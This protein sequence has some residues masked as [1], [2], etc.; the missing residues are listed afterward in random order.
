MDSHL[1]QPQTHKI[2]FDFGTTTLDAFYPKH[3]AKVDELMR[4]KGLPQI[5]GKLSNLKA[6]IIAKKLGL[7]DSIC[8]L[9]FY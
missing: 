5:T 1:P 7:K 2:Y 3:Q 4:K 6:K 9:S 8:L